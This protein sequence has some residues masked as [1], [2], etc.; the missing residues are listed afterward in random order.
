MLNILFKSSRNKTFKRNPC[1]TRIHMKPILTTHLS[2]MRWFS[3]KHSKKTINMCISKGLLLAG[4]PHEQD[5][6]VELCLN[7]RTIVPN[8]YRLGCPSSRQGVP[9]VIPNFGGGGESWPPIGSTNEL[10]LVDSLVALF[11][12][13]VVC[14]AVLCH[15][16]LKKKS[17]K[18]TRWTWVTRSI[19]SMVALAFPNP[20]KKLFHVP[21]C[22]SSRF[23]WR[24]HVRKPE[25]KCEDH[26]WVVANS[27]SNHGTWRYLTSGY[28]MCIVNAYEQFNH[29]KASQ[30]LIP[31]F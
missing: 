2:I 13:P 6:H 8:L 9:K 5:C 12:I 3:P 19:I 29:V 24:P 18:P 14:K 28:Q 23:S 15:K 31:C 27:R 4:T 7:H 22:S 30:S 20:E 16:M 11:R 1:E 25:E 17:P 10:R 21:S 26:I